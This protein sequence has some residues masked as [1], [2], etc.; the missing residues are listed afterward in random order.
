MN[1]P[2][3]KCVCIAVCRHKPYDKLFE[4]C[5]LVNDYEPSYKSI[6]AREENHISLIEIAL[7]PT[8]WE[9]TYR[10]GWV[11]KHNGGRVRIMPT[12]KGGYSN[13]E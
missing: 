5:E 8:K 4:D 11:H 9:F 7:N 1:C 10:Q 13:Y 6:Y 3:D 12:R 2:C